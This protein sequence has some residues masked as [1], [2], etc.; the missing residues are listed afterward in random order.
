MEKVSSEKHEFLDGEIYVMGGGSEEHSALALKIGRLLDD[1]VGERPCRVHTADLRIFVESIRLS[2]F[3]DGSVIC[4]P[5]RRY[6]PG[7]ETTA[8]NPIILVEVTSPSS[9]EYDLGLKREAYHTIPSLRE[10]VIVSHRERRI[11]VDIRNADGTWT[12]GTASRGERFELP[13]LE[14]TIEVDEI[15][16]KS[17]IP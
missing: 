16:R 7:P 8:L 5:L 13:S 3:P 2:T 4:G 17:T 14:A 9:E 11:T 6:E 15:Y 10:Y 12:T 1:V